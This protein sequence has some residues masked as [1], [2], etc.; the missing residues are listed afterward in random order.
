MKQITLRHFP[1][2]HH[3]ARDSFF[4]SAPLFP[5]RDRLREGWIILESG[6]W[7]FS[8][9]NKPP[10]PFVRGG[11]PGMRAGGALR[12]CSDSI[13]APPV[14]EFPAYDGEN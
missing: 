5:S 12:C 3:P 4:T 14:Q 7:V 11:L 1:N 8:I 6:S 13:R 10:P 9:E 2:N